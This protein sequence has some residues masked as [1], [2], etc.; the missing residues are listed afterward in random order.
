[1]LNMPLNTVRVTLHRGR[2]RLRETL[3]EEYDHAAV[4]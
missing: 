2:R 4:V 3:R 1:V